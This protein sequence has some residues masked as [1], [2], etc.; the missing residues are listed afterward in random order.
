[1]TQ[2]TTWK[3]GDRVCLKCDKTVCMVIANPLGPETLR[4]ANTVVWLDAARHMQ[5]EMV[6]GD[7][8]ELWGESK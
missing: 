1:M 8:L 6:P 4:H 7:A 2:S 5:K 3:T